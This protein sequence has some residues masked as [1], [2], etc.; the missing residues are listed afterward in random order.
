M[1]I[2]GDFDVNVNPHLDFNIIRKE[3]TYIDPKI[4]N[5]RFNPQPAGGMTTMRIVR[6]DDALK[7]S[8]A[9][10][11][12]VKLRLS[13]PRTCELLAL[14]K[15][16]DMRLTN[17]V[18]RSLGVIALDDTWTGA[19]PAQIPIFTILGTYRYVNTVNY[20]NAWMPEILFL[21]IVKRSEIR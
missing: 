21:G 16:S 12:L 4:Y 15:L 18:S 8:D 20:D 11:I 2:I 10:K 14:S 13:L 3:I 1:E 7:T 17:L 19:K 6:F 5:K 9:E